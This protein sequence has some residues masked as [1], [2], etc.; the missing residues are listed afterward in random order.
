MT[1]FYSQIVQHLNIM[2]AC[3]LIQIMISIEVLF[4]KIQDSV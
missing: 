3:V 1:Y 4:N 2:E